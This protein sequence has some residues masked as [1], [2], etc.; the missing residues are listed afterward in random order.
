MK[1]EYLCD[2]MHLAP[3]LARLHFAEWGPLLPAWSE[4]DALVELCTHQARTAIPTTMLAWDAA[5][6]VLIGSVSLLQNDDDRIRDYS[7]WLASLFVLPMYRGLGHGIALVH[8]CMREAA[9]L[10]IEQLFLYTAGQQAF[11][12]KLGW[13][14]VDN[15]A[16]GAGTVAVMGVDPLVALSSP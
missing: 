10:E 15:V 3:E 2:H 13:R 9:A 6:G 4:A 1:F 14:I 11:Y 5:N 7:P 12:Q 8:R 16:I